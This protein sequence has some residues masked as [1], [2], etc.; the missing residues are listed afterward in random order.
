L[1]EYSDG[2]SIERL[3]SAWMPGSDFAYDRRLRSAKVTPPARFSGAARFDLANKAGWRWSG[4]L[5][6]EMPGRADVPL[7]GPLLR[8]SL[9]P[10]E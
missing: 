1:S 2:I 4:D 5:T 9:S 10:S 3:T 6:V 7:T 8:A